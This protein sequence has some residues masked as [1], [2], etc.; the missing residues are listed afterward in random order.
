MA[1]PKARNFAFLIYPDSSPNDWR[2]RLESLG[3]PIA[4]S[5][6]HN[7]DKVERV[8]SPQ[9]LSDEER[10]LYQAG[11]L[12]KKPHRHILYIAKNP[13]TTEAV[14]NKIKRA[15]GEKSVQHVEIVDNVQGAYLYLTHESKDA[16]A[17]H[18]HVYPKKDLVLL[19]NFDIDRYVTLDDAQKKKLFNVLTQAI[20][21]Y[22]IENILD[23][24]D[25]I[26]D[27]GEEIGVPTLDVMN[28]VIAPR[29]GLLRLYLDGAYQRRLNGTRIPADK[30]TGEII[31]PTQK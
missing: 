16:K 2:T 4:A 28:D 3:L 9:D 15:L 22:K 5:P 12:F 27:H 14:R 8:E 6:I 29:T 17:K 30:Q 7:K 24:S 21:E 18:K 23:L 20:V 11:R 26:N 31:E 25:Y 19:N 10:D 13:V 1:K